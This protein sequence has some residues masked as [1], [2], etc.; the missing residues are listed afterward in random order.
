MISDLEAK[1][2]ELEKQC[3]SIP[4][5]L[6]KMKKKTEQELQQY[7]NDMEKNNKKNVCFTVKSEI[8]REGLIFAIFASSL[9]S[10][11]FNLVY[12]HVLPLQKLK[13]IEICLITEQ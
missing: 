11:T 4:E 9:N 12:I 5:A 7:R 1:N 6:D 8:F 10:R 13:N 3:A 2:R